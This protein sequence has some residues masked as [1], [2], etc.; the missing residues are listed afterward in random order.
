MELVLLRQVCPSPFLMNKE[1][2]RSLND[3]QTQPAL[4]IQSVY[5]SS[6]NSSTGEEVC[7]SA[8]SPYVKIA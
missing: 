1:K 8:Q 7:S 3:E 4:M 2:R 5:V 6:Y